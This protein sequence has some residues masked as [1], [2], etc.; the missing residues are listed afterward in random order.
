MGLGFTCII[1]DWSYL[2]INCQTLQTKLAHPKADLKFFKI[3]IFYYLILHKK[4][5]FIMYALFFNFDANTKKKI[6]STQLHLE[7]Q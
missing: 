4:N 1:L 3:N 2:T 6:I 5:I 7:C